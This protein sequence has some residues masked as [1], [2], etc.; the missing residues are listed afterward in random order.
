MHVVTKISQDGYISVSYKNNQI[1]STHSINFLGLTMDTTLPWTAQ[2][3]QPIPKLNL[4]CYVI[5]YLQSVMPTKVLKI[6][7]FAYIHPI[8]TLGII[9]W[10]NLP[11]SNDIFVL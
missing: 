4:A 7:Y 11:H 6:I 8:S 10:G 1:N 2:I 9:F 5:R 3:D